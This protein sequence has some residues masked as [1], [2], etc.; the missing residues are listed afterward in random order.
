MEPDIEKKLLKE[1]LKP[2]KALV[3]AINMELGM[4]YQHKMQTHYSMPI[5]TSVNAVGFQTNFCSTNWLSKNFIP[6]SASRTRGSN[7][8]G[9]V[10][11]LVSCRHLFTKANPLHGKT[12]NG[13]Y[14][15]GLSY[16]IS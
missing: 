15:Y 8:L 13:K 16:K 6:K 3:R 10:V 2:C 5:S 14:N 4:R 9:Y 11:I 1:T 12:M 7:W